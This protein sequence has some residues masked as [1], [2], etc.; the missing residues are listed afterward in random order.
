MKNRAQR[1]R[2]DG[3]VYTQTAIIKFKQK[4]SNRNNDMTFLVM[5]L[6]F[7]SENYLTLYGLRCVLYYSS[8]PIVFFF[9]I[10]SFNFMYYCQRAI[11]VF[12]F[13]CFFDISRYAVNLHLAWSWNEMNDYGYFAMQI[14]YMA[15][16][17]SL[18]LTPFWFLSLTLESEQ[19]IIEKFMKLYKIATIIHMG[20]KQ[21]FKKT[22]K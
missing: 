11:F 14:K 7:D 1:T 16:L 19:L 5:F 17:M 4:K 8:E 3:I 15:Q 18:M 13:V 9:Y 2:Y 12:V 20:K 10:L 6:W 22:Q 21:H